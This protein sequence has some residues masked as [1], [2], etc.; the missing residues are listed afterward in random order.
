MATFGGLFD[1]PEGMSDDQS[2]LLDP[3]DSDD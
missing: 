2:E 3:P 1:F